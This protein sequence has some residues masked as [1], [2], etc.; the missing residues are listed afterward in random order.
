[1]ILI[2]DHRHGHALCRAMGSVFTPSS[3]TVISRADL[4]TQAGQLTPL[5]VLFGGVIYEKFTG[6]SVLMHTAGMKP[7][8]LN[9]ELL[10]IAFDYPFRKLGCIKVI[11]PVASTNRK[12]VAFAEH[13]GFVLEAKIEDAVPGGDTLILSMARHDCR[14]LSKP[15]PNMRRPVLGRAVELGQVI[16]GSMH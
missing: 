11:S 1:M 4:V 3:E 6:T 7:N 13:L 12:A 14:W 9:R 16:S 8:W 5:E 15:P 10:W 2:N